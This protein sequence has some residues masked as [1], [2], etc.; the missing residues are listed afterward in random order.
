[1]SGETLEVLSHKNEERKEREERDTKDKRE[2]AEEWSQSHQG[3]QDHQGYQCHQGYQVHHGHQGPQGHHCNDQ[4]YRNSNMVQ[5][6]TSLWTIEQQ[7][8]GQGPMKPKIPRLFCQVPQN[9]R[10]D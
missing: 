7:A 3:H 4:I 2:E 8:K 5:I 10:A 6:D 9:R 1:M